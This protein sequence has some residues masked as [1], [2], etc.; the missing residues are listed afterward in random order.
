VFEK[1][2]FKVGDVVLESLR[3]QTLQADKIE[4]R[5]MLY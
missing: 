5:Y 4:V 1:H 2:F 3:G